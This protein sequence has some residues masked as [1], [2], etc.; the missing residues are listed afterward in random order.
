MFTCLNHLLHFLTLTQVS[1]IIYLV[2]LRSQISNMVLKCLH[3]LLKYNKI[4]KY[5]VPKMLRISSV[6][7]LNL[8]FNLPLHP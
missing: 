7:L 5:K 2:A 8:H 1:D 4:Y 6:N 3:L